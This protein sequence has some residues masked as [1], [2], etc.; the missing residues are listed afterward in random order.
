MS[1][2]RI[3]SSAHEIASWPIAWVCPS[4]ADQA[5]ILHGVTS[6]RTAV[7]L[8]TALLAVA[9]CTDDN[10]PPPTRPSPQQSPAPEGGTADQPVA[11]AATKSLLEWRPAPGA[12]D[13]TGTTNGTWFLTV[14]SSGQAYRL[15][16]PDQSFGTG[17]EGTRITNALLDSHW[18]VV[19]RQ[20]ERGRKPS[21]AE[22]TDLAKGEQ[23]T[24]DEASDAPT[25]D[26]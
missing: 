1:R 8:V 17:E 20:D 15:D 7:A 23:F 10:D 11:L 9:G 6:R 19:V 25:I 12:V 4:A 18:A 3:S 22:V 26:G 5:G 16:G 24:I 2:V 14:E 13:N 21:T